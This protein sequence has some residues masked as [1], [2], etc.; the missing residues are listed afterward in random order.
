MEREHP[1]DN[2]DRGGID[3]M[4]GQ[5][6]KKILLVCLKWFPS[7]SGNL[8]RSLMD[9]PRHRFDDYWP[10]HMH[11]DGFQ[12]AKFLPVLLCLSRF[13]YKGDLSIIMRISEW[14]KIFLSL[15]VSAVFSGCLAPV[16]CQT[17]CTLLVA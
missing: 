6:I 15:S 5:H 1:G 4:L 17:I 8:C 3:E 11:E 14:M 13:A 12:A 7:L 2:R 10:A 9:F 16:P